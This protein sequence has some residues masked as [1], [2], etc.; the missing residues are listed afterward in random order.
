MKRKKDRTIIEYRRDAE[1]FFR[2][3]AKYIDKRR[4]P[5][6]MRFLNK[7]VE[8]EP[9]N[10]DY[11]FNLAC[12]YAELKQTRKSN[13]I[14]RDIL[15]NIDPTLTECYF[16]IGCNYFDLG[17]LKKSKEYFEKYIY[18]DP[19]GQFVDETYDILYYLQVY[20]D[21]GLD[22]GRGRSFAKYCREG[23]KLIQ[24]K[25]Y[26]NACI[27]L[28]KA[29]ELDPKAVGP[30]NDLSLAYFLSGE[31]GKAVSLSKSVLK[32]NVN[33]VTANCNL[34]VFYA[35]MKRN[36]LLEKQM[37]V[38]EELKTV[39]REDLSKLVY[40]YAGLGKHNKIVT[41]LARHPGSLSENINVEFLQFLVIAL[42]NLK[43]FDSAGEFLQAIRLHCPQYNLVTDY[44]SGINEEAASGS[45][46]QKDLGYDYKLPVEMES[47]YI[48]KAYSYLQMEASMIKKAIHK[49][50]LVRDV[51][52]YF[53]FMGE[54]SLSSLI[55]VK[56]V[57]LEDTGVR[58][59]VEKAVKNFDRSDLLKKG[60]VK[61]FKL[62][63]RR[64]P[65]IVEPAYSRPEIVKRE[66]ITWEKEWEEIIECAMQKKEFIYKKTYKSELKSIL[67]NYIG[68]MGHERLPVIK[69][70]EAWAAALE[71]VYCNL[72]LIRV[73]KKTL[74]E[75]Y[76]VSAA[77]ITNILKNM[78]LMT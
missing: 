48:V 65:H 64:R 27:K 74:A 66:K 58:K 55:L 5:E 22:D 37:A 43:E 78:G 49:D 10:A 39:S 18:F 54:E 77:S 29:I 14:L 9:F 3:G 63:V 42:Y 8:L 47:E 31:K 70:R 1:L 20:D 15:N 59:L 61:A 76:N 68:M 56:L 13:T 25:D 19:E 16:G 17:N 4:F 50:S 45:G 53:L 24:E 44:I 41:A 51:L 73:S 26:K 46:E 38:L 62:K 23:K 30:R 69:K 60:I 40:T 34:A 71:Y 12:V 11:K 7:A 52:M 75:K 35:D 36:D 32:I 57:E 2:I 67:T 72:H 21:V 6:A 33:D 28:G